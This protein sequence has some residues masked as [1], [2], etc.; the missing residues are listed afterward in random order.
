VTNQSFSPGSFQTFGELLKYLRRREH[1]TQLEF[2]I[3][4]GYSDAQITRLEKNLRR[5]DLTALK[6]LFIPALRIENEPELVARFLEL[7]QSGR[8]EDAPSPGVA[9]YKG[10]LFFDESDAE[11]FFGREA[12]TSQLVGHVMDLAM[13]ATTRFLAV[14]GASGSGKSSLVRAGL[15]IALK[16]AG[17]EVCIF[18]PTASPLNMLET[19]LNAARMSN[20]ERILILVDQFEEVFTLC[21]DEIERIALIEKLLSAAQEESKKTTVVIALRADFYSHCAQYPL[22]RQA[23]AAEQEYMGQMTAQELRRAIEEPARRGGWDFEPGLV[24]VLLTDIGAHGSHEPEPGALPLLSHALLAT[25]E[26]R[27]RRT[28]TLDGYRASGGVHGAIA[29]TAESVFNDQLNRNQQELAR[30]VFLRLIELGE[31]TEDTRRRAALN[32]LVRQTTEATQLRTVLNTLAEAR[33]ITLNEDSAEVAHEALIREWQRLHEWLTQDRESL[34]L[35]R[36]LTESAHGWETRRRDPSELY[37]GARLAQ[38][39]EWVSA[40]EERLNTS[41]RAFLTASIAQEQRDALEREGQRQRELEAAQELADTQS[42]AAKQLRRRA[43]FLA[44]AF[45]LAIVL[46]GVAVFFGA[47]ANQNALEAQQNAEYATSR[48]LAAAAI[49]NLEEDPERSI[50]LALQAESTVHTTEAENALHRSIL[51]SRV[52]FV[53]PHDS[54]VASVTFSPDGKHIATTSRNGSVK[55]WD[56]KTGQSLLT[57]KGHIGSVDSIVYSSDG[58]RIAAT[59]STSGGFT[60]KV[61]DAITGEELLTLSGHTDFVTS[62]AFHPDGTRLVTTSIDGSAKVWDA[63]T[64]QELL[65][66][67]EH[68]DWVLD[69]AF[70]PDGK[71]IATYG[72]DG[73]VR[74]WEASSGEELLVLPFEKDARFGEKARFGRLTFSPDGLRVAMTGPGNNA[75]WVNM[76]D[77]TTGKVLFLGNLGHIGPPLDIAFSPDGRLAATGGIDQ[78]AKVWDTITGRVLYT[79]PGHAYDILSVAFSPDGTRLA[80]AGLDNTVRVWDLTPAKE[81]L[82]IPFADAVTVDWSMQLSYSPDGSRILTD[83]PDGNARIWDATT[84]TELLQ[85]SPRNTN[86]LHTSYSPDGKLLATA[87][88]DNTITVWD[89]QTGKPRITL[90][91]HN[92]FIF[93]TAFSPDGTSLA[94][95]ADGKIIIWDLASG[96]SLR[97]IPGPGFSSVAYSP[98][99]KRILSGYGW[100][101]GVIWDVATGESLFYLPGWYADEIWSVAYSADGKYLALGGHTGAIGIWDAK[102]GKQLLNLK[103]HGARISAI[104]FSPDGKWIA[105]ASADGTAHMWDTATGANLLSLPVDSGGAGGVSFSP[106]G[107]RLAVGGTSGVY[108]IVLPI[109]EV[110]ALAKSRL[111]RTL[112]T[113][114]C[115]Q[116]L[117]VEACPSIP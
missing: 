79:L 56:A 42:R 81:A 93:H 101:Q 59:S 28:F 3:M 11:L 5:P 2:S 31:G 105:A 108:V 12:L 99:G 73:F 34:L 37:R 25:W 50:L 102:T 57:F 65:T 67:S 24:D 90:V 104:V 64:G 94:S 89:G 4:V 33:L 72:Q 61:W 38:A 23:V 54:E 39:H 18:T 35:H 29:E 107:K 53:L 16:R 7:A 66:F 10:L 32:E 17:W 69:A 13:D 20:A 92:D 75:N 21:H 22:L 110:I 111:T 19:N 48:E 52:M 114:E 82:F 68:G 45:V 95:R 85:L 103:G 91:G 60:A 30:N 43:I 41:E 84:G 46:A 96:K 74:I 15:A 47:Q 78:K 70:N 80:T 44:G 8:Q 106:D 88:E 14:V 49:S 100:R 98:D 26:H 63:F 117:H 116:Y 76:W 77:A 1:L 97:A 115:Q 113:E 27:R 51:A 40:N 36:H 58:K 6:A 55:L 86:V 112:T 83:Y 71:R 109:E 87:N 9:P 62:V